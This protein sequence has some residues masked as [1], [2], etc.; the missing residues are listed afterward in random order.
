MIAEEAER[1]D[2]VARQV[3]METAYWLAHRH[4]D[5]HPHDRPRCR[6]AGRGDDV[7]RRQKSALAASSSKRIRD[8]VRPRLLEPLRDA[9]KIEFASLG[10]DAGYLG[11]AG[12]ARLDHTQTALARLLATKSTKRHNKNNSTYTHLERIV[13][14]RERKVYSNT[15]WR[16][17]PLLLVF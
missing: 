15:G 7:R 8:V 9:V 12:L 16:C 2:E 11:A 4:R 13:S 10:G 6:A 14:K 3:I 5:V 1:G 17:Y